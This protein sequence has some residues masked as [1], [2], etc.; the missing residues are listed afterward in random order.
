MNQGLVNG[1]KRS[2]CL[3]DQTKGFVEKFVKDVQ[4]PRK[5][6]LCRDGG[7]NTGLKF[8]PIVPTRRRFVSV[9]GLRLFIHAN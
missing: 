7:Q 8:T 4:A 1:V 2:L 5:Q 9:V 6:G 3:T